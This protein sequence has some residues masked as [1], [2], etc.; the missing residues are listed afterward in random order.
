VRNLED[1]LVELEGETSNALYDTLADWNA[2][3]KEIEHELE[4]L[5]R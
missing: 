4:R 5:D 2:V 1:C 3:L